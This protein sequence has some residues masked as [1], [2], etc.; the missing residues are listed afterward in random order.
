[1]ETL[2]AVSA[3]THQNPFKRQLCSY[4]VRCAHPACRKQKTSMIVRR[5][6]TILQT[7]FKSGESLC[8]SVLFR[9]LLRHSCNHQSPQSSSRI[10]AT[11]MPGDKPNVKG[12]GKGKHSINREKDSHTTA[13]TKTLAAVQHMPSNTQQEKMR[14]KYVPCI[15]VH[16]SEVA[17]VPA[18]I[19]IVD[20]IDT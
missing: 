6:L 12:S 15:S 13:Y 16:F 20:C 14:K 19:L 10:S 1:M 4:V 3:S 17:K 8:T 2:V 5:G 9:T 18:A 7:T 11:A